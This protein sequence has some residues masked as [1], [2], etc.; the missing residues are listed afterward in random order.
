MTKGYKLENQGYKLENQGYKLENQ[1]YKLENQGINWRT[2]VKLENQDSVYY[3]RLFFGFLDDT[4]QYEGYDDTEEDAIK[5]L[6]Y[7]VVP[8]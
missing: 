8:F 4:D 1:G 5:G 6:V 7:F 3:I 2:R